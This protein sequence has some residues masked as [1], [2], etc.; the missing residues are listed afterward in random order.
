M[1]YL[2]KNGSDLKAAGLL[3]KMRN[4]FDQQSYMK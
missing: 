2:N 4:K 1:T 3:K